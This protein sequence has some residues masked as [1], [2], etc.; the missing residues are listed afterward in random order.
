MGFIEEQIAKQK[1]IHC[2][3]YGTYE[4]IGEF[5][6]KD[7]TDVVKE[8]IKATCENIVE[9]AKNENYCDPPTKDGLCPDAK[10]VGNCYQC[11]VLRLLK[12]VKESEV[13]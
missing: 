2:V 13:E 4:A 12:Q 8:T 7:L 1:K 6:P 10:D 9:Y 5:Y 3:M 11:G